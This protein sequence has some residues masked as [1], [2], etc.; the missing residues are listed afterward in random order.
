MHPLRAMMMIPHLKE[1]PKLQNPSEYSPEF[2][3][4]ISKCL[5]KIPSQRATAQELLQV[6][7]FISY[8]QN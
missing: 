7:N 4:F 6:R 5:V 3:D 1:M 8:F 2:N